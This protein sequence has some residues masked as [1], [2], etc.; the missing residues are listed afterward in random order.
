M[1]RPHRRRARPTGHR[2]PFTDIV[3]GSLKK[4]KSRMSSTTSFRA[5]QCLACLYY[6]AGACHRHGPQVVS[7]TATGS[8]TGYKAV[9]PPVE[10]TDWC[11]EWAAQATR[12]GLVAADPLSHKQSKDRR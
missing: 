10:S 6:V 9:W 1:K 5:E 8:T 4:R 11:G 2:A 3:A 7:V 12:S